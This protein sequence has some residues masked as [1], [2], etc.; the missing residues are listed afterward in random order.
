MV[1][2]LFPLL[3]Q[4]MLLTPFSELCGHIN[5]GNCIQ[6]NLA[7]PTQAIQLQHLRAAEIQLRVRIQNHITTPVRCVD[8][9][10]ASNPPT[11]NPPSGNSLQFAPLAHRVGHLQFG[12]AVQH[13]CVWPTY[14][15]FV[16]SFLLY[17]S[18]AFCAASR[19]VCKFVDS[20]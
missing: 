14:A 1:P 15:T 2:P 19:S 11:Q 4:S 6:L 7:A 13:S 10:I 16:H 5:C 20:I 3:Q 9:G 18:T 8:L 17:I 12:A